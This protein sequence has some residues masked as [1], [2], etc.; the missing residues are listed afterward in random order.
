MRARPKGR[1]GLEGPLGAGQR[2]AGRAGGDVPLPPQRRR[3]APPAPHSPLG[4]AG[5]GLARR[6]LC[7]APPRLLPSLRVASSLWLPGWRRTPSCRQPS[8]DVSKSRP[9]R[10]APASRR[11]VR[12]SVSPPGSTKRLSWIVLR[13]FLGCFSSPRMA[14]ALRPSHSR[15]PEATR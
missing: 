5:C 13:A 2:K 15:T 12:R 9:P 1:P 4:A 10:L 6:P 3:A 14:T 11:H 8:R 7:A